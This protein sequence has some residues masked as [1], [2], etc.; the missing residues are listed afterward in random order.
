MV[1]PFGAG[2]LGEVPSVWAD[3]D[4]ST[5]IMTIIKINSSLMILKKTS[6]LAGDGNAGQKG[7]P[8]PARSFTDFQ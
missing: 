5:T 2:A 8:K 1:V 7:T 3:A 4:D 6:Q